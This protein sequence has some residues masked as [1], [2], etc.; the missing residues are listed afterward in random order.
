MFFIN[1]KI[2]NSLYIILFVLFIFIIFAIVKLVHSVHNIEEDILNT[3]AQTNSKKLTTLIK[4][5]QDSTLAIALVLSNNR[6]IHELLLNQKPL[7]STVS[8]I[9]KLLHSNTQY[10]SAW[11][12]IINKKGISLYRSWTSK[13]GDNISSIRKDL[14]KMQENPQIMNTISTG[15]YDMTFK[16]MVPIFKDDTFIGSIEIITKFNSIAQKIR[17][18]NIEP[19]IL[20]DKSYKKQLTKPFSNRFVEDYYVVNTNA[21]EALLDFIAQKR[22]KTF[23]KRKGYDIVDDY[24]VSYYNIDDVNGEPMAMTLLF[25]PL[26]SIQTGHLKEFKLLSVLLIGILLFAFVLLAGLTFMYFKRKEQEN[27]N[28]MLKQNNEQLEQRVKKEIEKSR[29]KDILM[30]QQ[31]KMAALGEMLGHIA[32]QWRQ[33]LSAISTATSGLQLKHEFKTLSNEDFADLTNGIMR[34]TKYLS[35]TIEDFRTY[36]Q[37]DK[38]QKGFNLSKLIKDT[39]NIIKALYNTKHIHLHLKCDDTIFYKGY[40][41]ELSQ[42]LL[43]LFNNAKD[44]LDVVQQDPKIVFIK[45]YRKNSTIYIEF[46]DNAGGILK[47]HQDKIFEPY[48]TTKHESHGTGIGL[49]MCKEIITKHFKGEI[50]SRNEAFEIENKHFFGA[51]FIIKLTPES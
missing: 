46:H 41:N 25:S 12:H 15:M 16:S 24:F 19:I 26:K 45:T 13:K 4:N 40:Q 27:L 10:S 14:I 48:F 43:N 5:Q 18:D 36:F 23:W 33:P 38:E 3:Q 21:N 22:V 34:N 1:K 47:Q 28:S 2:N 49:Y 30:A 7:D 39:Y 6:S 9:A 8:N 35:D 11:I 50:F 42:V 20:V 51:N 44:A 31:T 29:K 37:K 17:N 32:H